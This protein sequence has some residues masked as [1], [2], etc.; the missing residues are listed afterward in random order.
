MS[1]SMPYIRNERNIKTLILC[2]AAIVVGGVPTLA[3]EKHPSIVVKE[4]LKQYSLGDY[5]FQW[6]VGETEKR[7]PGQVRLGYAVY[8]VKPAG[9]PPLVNV[10]EAREVNVT[11]LLLTEEEAIDLAKALE[12]APNVLK[13]LPDAGKKLDNQRE[14]QNEIEV[15]DMLLPYP[16]QR[17]G[18]SDSL[19]IQHLHAGQLMLSSLDE[20]KMI[21]TAAEIA[22][23]LKNAPK[24]VDVVEK[25]W[26]S[27][28]EAVNEGN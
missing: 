14:V 10:R 26:P 7:H 21:K 3:A 16:R 28:F 13:D 1:K 17:G 8:I 27:Q 19:Y 15:S 18:S 2:T 20:K 9:E 12:D 25:N 11:G 22:K 24:H 6:C 5:V 23:M 4:Q